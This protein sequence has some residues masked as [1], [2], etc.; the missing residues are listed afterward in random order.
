LYA[1]KYNNVKRLSEQQLID[2]TYKAKSS[3]I[4]YGCDGGWPEN[5]LKY[6]KLRGLIEEASYPYKAT[7]TSFFNIQQL[8]Y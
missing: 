6:A 7:V 8:F 2:C 4:N 1:I 5:G 3:Y